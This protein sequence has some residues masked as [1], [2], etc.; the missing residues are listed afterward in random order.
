MNI[1]LQS[2]KAPHAWELKLVASVLLAIPSTALL[3][4]A[5]GEMLGG[6]VSGSQHLVQALPL[7]VL[8]VLGWRLPR[9]AG[10]VLL[11]VGALLLAAWAVWVL[12]GDQPE[13]LP[14]GLVLFAPALIAGWLLRRAHGRGN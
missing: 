12:T 5:A 11:V 9:I 4:L 1:H 7:L 13:I 10:N 8:L 2:E 14:F 3:V 6:D